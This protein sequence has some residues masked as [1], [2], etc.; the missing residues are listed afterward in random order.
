MS[1]TQ[2]FPGI[3]NSPY[4]LLSSGITDVATTIP[5][6]EL[7]VFP[8]A[9]N[10][11]VIGTGSDAET[12][13]ITAKSAATGAGTLT[14]TREWNKTGTVGAKKAWLAGTV[15]SRRFTEYDHATFK[16]NIE[17]HETWKIS[18]A[19]VDAKGDLIVATAA[20]TVVRHP[21]G[22]DL[23]PLVAKSG[24]TNGI[25]YEQLTEG[26]IVLADVTTLN[27]STSKHG[28]VPKAPND[29]SQYLRG[30]GTWSALTT[31]DI[32]IFK[33]TIDCAAN[34]NYPAAD[35]GHT[36][37]VSV[38]GKIG[39]A[40]GPAVEVGDMIVCCVDSTASGDHA[41]V[42]AN[43]SILQ[44]VVT[45]TNIT[46][47]DVT[48]N[49]A[50]T[51]KH[52]FAPKAT[53]PAAGIINLLGIANGE[54]AYTCKALLDDTN[55]A[56]L[57]TAGPGTQVIAARR[58][59]IHTM[60]TL[61]GVAAPTDV[62]TL[63]ATT[64]AH[65]LVLKATAPAAGVR[66]VIAIDNTETAYK[67]TALVDNTNPAALGTVS[68]GTSLIAA[69]RDHVHT[70]PT[71]DGVA[72]PTDVT[73]LNVSASAHGLCPKFPNNATTFFRGDGTY[74]APP[75]AGVLS[76]SE[77]TGTTQACAV[78]VG[79]IL[80]HATTMIVATLPSTA[81]V[82]D[83]VRIVG[84]GAA[85]W[86]LAQN[87]SQYIRFAGLSTTTGTGGYLQAENAYDCVELLCTTANNG[88]TVISSIGNIV[89]V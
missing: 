44:S 28:L 89:V 88:W 55:P 42:G 69:R 48:T 5:V 40:S 76:W 70:M 36:Y 83:V 60:P 65:G 79:Y 39:G 17:D 19:I 32:L 22:T 45:E 50:S 2:M 85:M 11:A 6:F 66:N 77:V 8:A 16:A 75:K 52:G 64:S 23:Y 18:K 21:V 15:I 54:T 46:L 4:T 38:A 25:A 30:D 78:N 68:P 61:D 12:V 72:A 74:A 26:G 29:T 10:I 62:T 24:V 73:T 1:Q 37:L 81:A 7:G 84:K 53:A 31:P 14:V 86:K 56:A 27:V 35:A 33:G 43:W 20:D 87:A 49:D 71:L 41:T 58:D 51:T 13:L 9:P 63:D 67:N 34:P 47:S 82:G 59:H 80:N 57:G 3:V